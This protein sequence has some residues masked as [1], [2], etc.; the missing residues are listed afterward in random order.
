MASRRRGRGRLLIIVAL[1][2]IIILAVVAVTMGGGVTP[3]AEEAEATLPAATPTKVVDTVSIIVLAQP[4]KRGH[5][6]MDDMI[7]TIDYP[8]MKMIEGLFLT[9]AEEVIGKRA[10]FDLEARIPLTPGMLSDAADSSVASFNIPSGYVAISIP[11]D[12]LSAVSYALEPGDHVNI[13]ASLFFVDLDTDYQTQLP[14]VVAQVLSPASSVVMPQS[15]FEEGEGAESQQLSGGV[16]RDERTTEVDSESSLSKPEFTGVPVTSGIAPPWYGMSYIGRP[17]LDTTLSG[18][19]DLENQWLY[20]LPSERYQR[21]RLVSLTLIQ[22]AI[23]L[24]VGEFPRKE[25]E[26]E[27][28]EEPVA[29]E[30][31]PITPPQTVVEPI[32][33]QKEE[34]KKEEWLPPDIVTLVVEPQDAVT[35]N[36]LM[37]TGADLNLVLRS[38]GDYNR[39]TAETVTL[40]FILEQYNIPNPSKL[41]YGLEPRV[42][43][44]INVTQA[45]PTPTPIVVK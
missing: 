29:P 36:Y 26:V 25:P 1:I 24:W 6:I 12:R 18:E 22:D 31:T 3:E 37:I 2:L 11:I 40:Q 44:F 43:D 4:I 14:N 17:E 19:R 39:I 7:A 35:L 23:V 13:I 20:L 10:L 27:I 21:P 28:T 16:L 32:E 8:I 5:V 41:P 42:D 33:I 45:T 30:T 15:V 9:D 34:E 38:A